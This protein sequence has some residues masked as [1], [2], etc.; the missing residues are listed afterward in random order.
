M[1]NDRLY[2]TKSLRQKTFVFQLHEDLHAKLKAT[3]AMRGI[4]MSLMMHK[5]IYQ[6]LRKTAD[7]AEEIDKE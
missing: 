1:K 2:D 7:N 6:Y 5:A 4:S 3:A